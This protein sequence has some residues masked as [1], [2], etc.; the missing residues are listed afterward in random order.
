MTSLTPHW[1]FDLSKGAKPPE[2]NQV[3][4]LWD[5]RKI[6]NVQCLPFLGKGP[7]AL[8]LLVCVVNYKGGSNRLSPQLCV[9]VKELLHNGDVSLN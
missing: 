9:S 2:V 7:V 3:C 5:G 8:L 4:Y 1:E 6:P